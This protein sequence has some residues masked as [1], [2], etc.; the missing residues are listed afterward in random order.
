M[1]IKLFTDT[2]D[3]CVPEG[4]TDIQ[5]F[6]HWMDQDDFPETGNIWW[7]KGAVWADMSKEQIF[8]HADVKLEITSVLRVLAK[9]EKIGR[10]LPDGVLL[11]N[12]AGDFS[13]KPDGIFISNNSIDARK[14]VYIEGRE[15]GYT[16]IQ[17]SPDIVLEIVSR[18]SIGKDNVTL[19]QAC[20]EAEI[21]E[22]WLV[23]VRNEPLQFD[24]L[25]RTARGY[26][27]TRKKD[28][29]VKSTVLVKSFRLLQT[30]ERGH[31]SFTL[32]VG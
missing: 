19:R 12:F 18:S 30:V 2:A 32:E 28:G 15:T 25:R 8:T 20:W 7:L 31:P 1:V 4:I 16:E 27:A 3:L 21:P 11:T 13:G 17:G 29:W 5:S 9:S 22:Y 10:V 26:S 23:D 24:I 14:V 6:R